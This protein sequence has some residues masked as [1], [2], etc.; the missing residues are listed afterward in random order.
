MKPS[1]AADAWAILHHELE[2]LQHEMSDPAKANEMD[3]VL[4]RLASTGR[5]RAFWADMALEAQA[6]EVLHGLGF[7][8]DQIDGDVGALS[9]VG[10]CASPLLVFFWADPMFC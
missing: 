9:R 7:K 8:D 1:P 3:R 2:A 4:A 5:I 10:R 6:R